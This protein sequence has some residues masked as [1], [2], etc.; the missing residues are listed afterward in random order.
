MAQEH[1][2]DG[3]IPYPFSAIVGNDRPKGAL[4]CALSSPDISSML[5]CGPKGSGKTVLARSASGIGGRMTVTVPLNATEDG[6]FG[7]MDLEDT[8]R[9]G[10]AE[11]V[12]EVQGGVGEDDHVPGKGFLKNRVRA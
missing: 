10:R 11:G 2:R 5:I 8:L 7:G 4:R 3:V 6:I 1:V 9:D 12:V